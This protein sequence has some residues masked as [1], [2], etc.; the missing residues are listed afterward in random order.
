MGPTAAEV[1]NDGWIAVGGLHV[2][3]RLG[4]T[5][6]AIEVGI[7]LG[8]LDEAAEAATEVEGKTGGSY[9]ATVDEAVGGSP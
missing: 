8:R 4:W 1:A 3:I 2:V 5:G 9:G 6:D 7:R